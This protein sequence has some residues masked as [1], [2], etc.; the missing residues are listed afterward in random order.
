MLLCSKKVGSQLAPSE[1]QERQARSRGLGRRPRASLVTLH[2]VVLTARLTELG[3]PR[4]SRGFVADVTYL[5]YK[6]TEQG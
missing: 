6:G 4:Q 1:P 3:L 5:G 2:K